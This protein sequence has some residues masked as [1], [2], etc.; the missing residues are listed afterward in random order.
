ME[1]NCYLP[2]LTPEIF[3]HI[4]D[5]VSLDCHIN[6]M[7]TCAPF[8]YL[9]SKLPNLIQTKINQEPTTFGK[10]AME[11]YLECRV[12]PPKILQQTSNT[13]WKIPQNSQYI[14]TKYIVKC[15]LPLLYG[16]LDK[17]LIKDVFSLAVKNNDFDLLRILILYVSPVEVTSTLDLIKN[18]QMQKELYDEVNFNYAGHIKLSE[19]VMTSPLIM[20][21]LFGINNEMSQRVMNLLETLQ[22]SSRCIFSFCN[23]PCYI[24][25]LNNYDYYGQLHTTIE[26]YCPENITMVKKLQTISREQYGNK[27]NSIIPPSVITYN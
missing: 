24:Q 7:Q 9:K 26:R 11:K 6:L 17:K 22:L 3:N 13:V 14:W 5:Y 19:C 4:L 23:Q 25:K 20:L 18:K 10:P 21:Q 1:S 16:S 27:N 15:D 12:N 2:Y 8:T